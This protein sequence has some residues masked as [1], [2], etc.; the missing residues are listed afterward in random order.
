VAVHRM[1]SRHSA[2]LDGGHQFRA[3]WLDGPRRARN[4]QALVEGTSARPN[5]TQLRRGARRG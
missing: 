5:S 3:S 4:R 2:S 1:R